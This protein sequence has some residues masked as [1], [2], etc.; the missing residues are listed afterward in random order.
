MKKIRFHESQLNNVKS[1]FENKENYEVVQKFQHDSSFITYVVYWY[2]RKILGDSNV[3]VYCNFIKDNENFNMRIQLVEHTIFGKW[4]VG[5]RS[6]I[7]V[8]E[9]I[10]NEIMEKCDKKI[11]VIG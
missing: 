4:S 11:A 6:N 8:E 1:V 9:K 5:K 7:K 2:H 10:L 3:A